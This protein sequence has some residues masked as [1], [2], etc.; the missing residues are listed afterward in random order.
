MDIS[1]LS[2]YGD[3]VSDLALNSQSSA[4][5]D[6]VKNK[7]YANASDDELMDACKQFET[8]FLEQMMKK[9]MDTV[10]TEEDSVMNNQLVS[11]FM[12]S[13]LTEL[14]TEATDQDSLGIAQMLYDQMKRTY[15]V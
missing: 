11:Y 8:Y 14:C 4:L 1:G 5:T 13:T 6:S 15:E 2:G 9:M 12:D 10:S 3:Y 7:D